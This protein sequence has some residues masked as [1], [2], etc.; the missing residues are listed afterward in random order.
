M[1]IS[2]TL[3]GGNIFFLKGKTKNKIPACQNR[4]T[5]LH[6]CRDLRREICLPVFHIWCILNQTSYQHTPAQSGSGLQC[7]CSR[8]RSSLPLPSTPSWRLS[9]Q[10]FRRCQMRVRASPCCWGR[11]RPC[12][13]S[14]GPPLRGC[15]MHWSGTIEEQRWRI[16]LWRMEDWKNKG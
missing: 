1:F 14:C 10:T 9:W 12:S 6:L 13:W 3:T 8:P 4:C 2:L 16:H 5:T 7:S 15:Q 11:W